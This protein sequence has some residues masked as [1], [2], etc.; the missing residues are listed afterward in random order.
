MPEL[1]KSFTSMLKALTEASEHINVALSGGTTPNALFSYW[2]ENCREAIDWKC[3]SF[4][5]GDERCV[6][7]DDVMSNYGTANKYL[8]SKVP[9]IQ[10]EN[11]H[12][13]FGENNPED[14]AVRYGKE[15]A[16][17]LPLK[18]GIPEFDL[19]M[20]GMGDDGHTASIFP[21]CIDLW[22][23][24]E[25]CVVAAHPETGMKRVSFTG[26]VINNAKNVAFLVTGEKKTDKV[27][28]IIGDRKNGRSLYPA[29]L[30]NPEDGDLLWYL[31]RK[32]AMLL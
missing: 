18:N 19:I 1:C 24:P 21:Y 7:P 26:R 2:V 8:F 11:I 22:N 28:A 5:W 25:N 29:A 31:D 6:A 13:I 17:N 10:K 9:E 30:V 23:A 16:E 32:A 20:L 12:R 3:I 15:M 14:E 4:Y 27:K